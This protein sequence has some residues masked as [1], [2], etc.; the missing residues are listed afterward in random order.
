V[1]DL[2]VARLPTVPSSTT[3]AGKWAPVILRRV[4]PESLFSLANAL[5]LP[6]WL[7]LVF[8]PRWRWSARF[9]SGLVI[10]CLLGLLYAL[11]LVPRF[12]GAEGGFGS[13]A[14]VRKLFEDP[15]LLLAGWVH[16]LAFD[17]FIGAWEVRDAQRRGVPHLL[18]VPCLF[19]TFMFGPIG[20]L[21]YVVI[22]V[23]RARRL[24]IDETSA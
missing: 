3:R 18:V 22:R 11:V 24:A 23:V 8:A 1:T 16:Y 2:V 15:F 21:L 7:L 12:G 14:E 6:G 10:P 17:L 20:L 9:V 5:V 19:L 4:T 13:L